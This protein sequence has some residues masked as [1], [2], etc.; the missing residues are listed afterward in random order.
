[1]RPT[2]DSFSEP[3]IDRRKLL[4]GLLFCSAAGVA[5]WRQ[6]TKKLDYLGQHKLD[7]IV[8]KAIGA[9]KF[10]AASGLVLPLDD[11]YLHSIYN[12][13][14][15][16]IYS[17]GVNPP[18]MLLLAQSGSQTGFL[19]IHR[20]ETCY[21]AGGYQV[22]PLTPHPVQVGKK[23]VHANAMEAWGSGA[24]EHVVYWTR[25]G[26]MMPLSWRDQKI[27]V[28]K[29]NLEGIIPDAILV[30]I[31]TITSDADLAGAAIDNFIRAL[32]ESVPSP[33]KSV[34]IA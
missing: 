2:F 12:Q 14:L 24:P 13:L 32:I 9:W 34:F 3:I 5:A 1:M 31:S 23:V 15:T 4:L 20:P 25:I 26:N 7:D 22:S 30:R 19:Q 11:P 18:I 17:D 6:P 29:Q 16:R 10:M 21:T 27:A 8:P 33:M 28:A